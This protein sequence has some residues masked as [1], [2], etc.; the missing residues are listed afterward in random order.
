MI[1]LSPYTDHSAFLHILSISDN[2]SCTI[3]WACFWGLKVTVGFQ[4]T[5]HILACCVPSS[6]NHS[7]K[8][9]IPALQATPSCT[10]TITPISLSQFQ[11]LAPAV[12][13]GADTVTAR[14]H[15]SSTSFNLI[16]PGLYKA[17]EIFAWS[18]CWDLQAVARS[19]IRL[20]FDVRS[21]SNRSRT[22]SNI[23]VVTTA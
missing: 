1:I 4:P 2:L 15:I 7:W 6:P 8:C 11:G 20:R 17:A 9:V 10:T 14:D 21:T 19:M 3:Y 18:K 22:A 5:L 12:Q 13:L 23:A 16:D